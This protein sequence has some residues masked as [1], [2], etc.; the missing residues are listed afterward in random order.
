MGAS[1]LNYYVGIESQDYYT[2]PLPSYLTPRLAEYLYSGGASQKHWNPTALHVM[3]S[4]SEVQSYS[5]YGKR[6]LAIKERM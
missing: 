6:Q 2:S 5:A 4:E 1:K 3:L